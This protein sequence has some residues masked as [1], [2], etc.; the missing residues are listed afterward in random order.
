MLEK[1]RQKRAVLV[2]QRDQLMANVNVTSGAI[3]MVDELI[4][5]AVA[6]AIAVSVDEAGQETVEEAPEQAS[7]DA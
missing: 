4:G 7:Q 6:E 1:L 3:A 5:E 2:A